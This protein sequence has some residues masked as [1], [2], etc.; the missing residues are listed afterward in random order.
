MKNTIKRYVAIVLTLLLCLA[1]MPS[2]IFADDSKVIYVS[3]NGSDANAGTLDRPLATLDAARDR[4]R[5]ME[6]SKDDP[7]T[8][9]L[10]GGTYYLKKGLKLDEQDNYTTY[11]AYEG[12]T[13]IIT[14]AGNLPK[15]N[16]VLETDETVLAR[17]PEIAR[18]NLKT[19]N[20][21]NNG[22]TSFGYWG[23]SYWPR[24]A[25]SFGSKDSERPFSGKGIQ[26]MLI[27]NGKMQDLSKWPNE[28][29]DWVGK[30]L[31]PPYAGV[32]KYEVDKDRM[33]N[34]VTADQAYMY[35]FFT[36][37]YGDGPAEIKG[38]DV[39]NGAVVVSIAANQSYRY[40]ICNLLEE[41]DVPGEFFLDRNTGDMYFFENPE[42]PIETASFAFSSDPVI[43]MTDTSFI[44]LD[45]LTIEGSSTYGVYL[46]LNCTD[47]LITNCNIGNCGY[48]VD[49]HG[50][51]NGVTNCYIHN[52]GN[53]GVHISNRGTQNKG[54]WG[55]TPEQNYITYNH[56]QD[57]SMLSANYCPPIKAHGNGN[58]ISHN[59]IHDAQQSAINWHGVGNT[60][61]Y[62]EAYDA[63]REGGD[64]GVFYD[65]PGFTSTGNV[66]DHNF[67]HA[68]YGPEYLV[69]A[70]GDR[71]YFMCAMYTDNCIVGNSF[72]NNLFYDIYQIW[73]LHDTRNSTI[74]NNLTIKCDIAN[75]NSSLNGNGIPAMLK[76]RDN[77]LKIAAGEMSHE[78]TE[79]KAIWDDYV[80]NYDPTDP[81]WDKY[82]YFKT[83]ITDDPIL[84]KYNIFE[85]NVAFEAKTLSAINEAA[86]KW[87]TF[88][89]NYY[90][91]DPM[92]N[93]RDPVTGEYNIDYDLIRKYV[94]DF[95][96]LE[97]DK[98][99]TGEKDLATG[100]FHV[101][102]PWNNATDVQASS[103][104]FHWEKA[105]G[106]NLYR[107]MIARD[108]EFKD[109]IY[110][111]ITKEAYLELPTLKYG[112][113]TYYWKVQA[114]T[115]SPAYSTYTW[116]VGGTRKFTTA[117]YENCT[118]E[119]AELTIA[120]AQEIIATVPVGDMEG[121]A[122][123]ERFDALKIKLAAAE[124]A[125]KEQKSQRHIDKANEN[126]TNE[127]VT[128]HNSRNPAYVDFGPMIA[129]IDNWKANVTVNFDVNS[130]GVLTIPAPTTTNF[131]VGYY[132]RKIQNY[133]ILKF[134]M[135]LGLCQN[136][137]Q[138]V[139]IR[140]S[141]PT[142]KVPW[143][144]TNSSYA[145]L[146][147]TAATSGIEFQRFL[148]GGKILEYKTYGTIKDFVADGWNDYEMGCLQEGENP[149]F[150]L[151]I[152]GD[153]VFDY[154]V[155]D[156]ANHIQDPAYFGITLMAGSGAVQ[157]A[158][159]DV[160]VE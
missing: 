61:T 5:V 18:D 93:F 16:W 154:V 106:A 114:Q 10:R 137:W 116:N 120:E 146:F 138:V 13:P 40:S 65:W 37:D 131:G 7:V 76:H 48:A 23:N 100:D 88:Q 140:S 125:V 126:L 104:T 60:I 43:E 55:I 75:Y 66:L 68:C 78:G 149:R 141:G 98:F 38:W 129:D 6:K 30:V 28:H 128:F 96:E 1:A 132:G 94:P 45:G 46:S 85:R 50:F 102:Y 14:I 139:Q 117:L 142:A 25:S 124:K 64:A 58:T 67:I 22:I 143:D 29:Y 70:N 119:K 36:N 95:E 157:L 47:N 57:T 19:I 73:C 59:R 12:E 56:M 41:I 144:T 42:N 92:P 136:N 33:K 81:E 82:P 83:F 8:I 49:M 158:G 2:N 77:M 44:T 156:K 17:V 122:T 109:M 91:H 107:V 72:Q 11:K 52:C 111:D 130:K 39:E 69:N 35:G 31:E 4:A 127:I 53:G 147:E 15:E 155:T 26:G 21:P 150:F 110:D 62:N 123:Q 89:N 63:C 115:T 159:A 71:R 34:W 151:K 121:G 27:V 101:S 135:K 113:K 160:E 20:L 118:T 99:G 133:E 103:L 86:A 145:L 105:K 79:Y 148:T 90:T 153:L 152:N 108:P 51:R 134:K 24:M 32:Y 54:F 9:V 84:P 97:F 80:M 87:S 112:K 74:K 3:T